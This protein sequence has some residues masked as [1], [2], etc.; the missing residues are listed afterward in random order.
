MIC[1]PDETWARTVL[2]GLPFFL[3]TADSKGT[4]T[5][6][7]P[8]L[9]ALLG[10][11]PASELPPSFWNERIHDDDRDA[12]T[13]AWHSALT[14]ATEMRIE[15]RLLRAD[16]TYRWFESRARPLLGDDGRPTQWVGST[17]DIEE[18]VATRS[19]LRA[20]R[21]RLANIAEASPGML[22]SYSA[23]PGRPARFPYVS[24]TFVK[25]FQLDPKELA[26]DGT[27]FFRLGNP[28][29]LADMVR[30]VEASRRELSLW[31]HQWRVTAPELGEI[32]LEAHSMPVREP[33]GTTTWHGT[34]S[35]VTERRRI[36]EQLRE[37]NTNLERRVAQRTA[38]L[39]AANRELEAANRELEAFSYSV[40]HD[41]REPLRA[42]NGFSKA[43]LQD[44]GAAL[45]APAQHFIDNIR[46]GGLRMGQLIDDLLAFSRLSRQPLKRRPLDMRRLVQDCVARLAP[47][48][49]TTSVTIGEL[50][51]C[52]ADP[53]LIEQVLTNL[54]SNAFKYSRKKPAP[55]ITIESRQDDSQRTVYSVRDNGTGFN[56]K[57]AG[58]LFQV[59][60]RLHRSGEF[61][62]TGVGLA[63]VHR[64]VTRHGG[65]VWAEAEPARGATFFFTLEA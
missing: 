1:S 52:N 56:M 27:P 9:L 21:L 45:P 35:D 36:D 41:L 39:E 46:Q 32:W 58:K 40:S 23:S 6:V 20:E 61:E 51:G 3:W 13:R 37:L 28:E 34:V 48:Y 18:E 11:D 31:R 64:I 17:D 53:G 65:R 2:T 4:L 8:R 7:D 29:D 57:Y 50:A 22:F 55:A 19:A 24:P 16:G 30:T 62:G 43:L 38:E 10:F 25:L 14:A 5:Y 60:Q 12:T 15:C 47:A 63:I 44:F 42:I 33:D 54:L 26:N 59:F 49:P